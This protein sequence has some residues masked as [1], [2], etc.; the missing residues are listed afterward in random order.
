MRPSTTT[1]SPECSTSRSPSTSSPGST[2]RSLPSRI[3]VA[4]G[5]GEDGDAVQED[6]GADLLGQADERVEDDD[7]DG[8]EGVQIA[9]ED[10]QQDAEGKEDV[11]DEVEDVLAQDLAIGAARLVDDDVAL[12]GVATPPSLG[13]REASRRRRAQRGPGAGRRAFAIGR[14]SPGLGDGR[15]VADVLSHRVGKL[16]A[17]EADGLAARHAVWQ[18]RRRPLARPRSPRQ[19]AAGIP[20]GFSG[21]RLRIPSRLL[22]ACSLGA[23]PKP[24][25]GCLPAGSRLQPALD[26][27]AGRAATTRATG[28]C[29]LRPPPEP[30]GLQPCLALRCSSA[31]GARRGPCDR[32][33][34]RLSVST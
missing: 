10:D 25:T 28:S 11:V 27:W 24:S 16:S 3:T 30:R 1:W 4:F 29:L 21:R 34:P 6:L 20:D 33:H 17:S 5:L 8:D 14:P 22:T 2:S 12:T 31:P 7:P 19:R 15:S 13:L 18:R 32:C 23:L 9:A 26:P